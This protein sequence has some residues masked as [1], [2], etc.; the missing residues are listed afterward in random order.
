M[1]FTTSVRL[2][3]SKF[4]S[5]PSLALVLVPRLNCTRTIGPF[6]SESVPDRGGAEGVGVCR[7][8]CKAGESSPG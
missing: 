5:K 8:G 7:D 4:R 2:A 6:P 3:F 1:T